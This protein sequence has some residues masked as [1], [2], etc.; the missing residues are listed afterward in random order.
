[1]SPAPFHIRR[2]RPEDRTACA[3]VFHDAVHQGAAGFYDAAQR[4]AWAPSPLPRADVPDKLLDQRCFVAERDGQVI[5]LMSLCADGYLDMAFVRPEVMGTG[6]ADAL[7]LAVLEEARGLRLTRLTTHA[8][9]LAR[10][11]FARRGWQV[12]AAETHPHNGQ[13]FERFAMSVAVAGA[14]QGEE[15]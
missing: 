6:V 11:F 1:M 10:R 5:G 4:A 13:V 9:H 2:Y 3:Q 12:D 8:S 7:Y 14:G 15:G